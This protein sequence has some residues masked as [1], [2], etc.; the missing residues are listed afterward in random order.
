LMPA[1][2]PSTIRSF[3]LTLGI[4]I[5]LFYNTIRGQALTPLSLQRATENAKKASLMNRDSYN[6]GCAMKLSRSIKDEPSY[7]KAASA[8]YNPLTVDD[9]TFCGSP[10][11]SLLS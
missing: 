9:C 6:D 11:R 3:H 2:C 8:K 1:I 5:P 4:C 7:W 10:A